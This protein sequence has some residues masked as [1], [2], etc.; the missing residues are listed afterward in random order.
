MDPVQLETQ[1]FYARREAN[2]DGSFIFNASVFK[3]NKIGILDN[4]GKV[5]ADKAL[6]PFM[7]RETAPEPKPVGN[8]A[9]SGKSLSWESQGE[10]IRYVVYKI[11][12]KEAKIADVV[13][14]NSYVCVEPGDYAVSALN[15]D[16]AESNISSVLTIK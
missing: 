5:Y 10:G 14:T 8:L 11:N 1:F 6:I 2:V 3:N 16:N 7:G 12:D 9:A 13:D 4:L 15:D